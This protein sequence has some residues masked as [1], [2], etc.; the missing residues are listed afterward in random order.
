MTL[1]GS[2]VL[3]ILDALQELQEVGSQAEAK[4]IVRNTEVR[5]ESP[6][7]ELYYVDIVDVFGIDLLHH[8][9]LGI[10]RMITKQFIEGYNRT[11]IKFVELYKRK[12][13]G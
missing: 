5:F 1:S 6:L 12:E 9:F 7:L 4:K 13:T 10:A 3:Q 2:H 11:F 8:L